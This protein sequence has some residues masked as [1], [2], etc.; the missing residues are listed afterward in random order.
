[1]INFGRDFLGPTQHIVPFQPGH[2]LNMDLREDELRYV[3][4]IPNWYQYLIESAEPELTWTALRDNEPY[5]CF[6][7]HPMWAGVSEVWMV[8]GRNISRNPIALV[9]GARHIFDTCQERLG[10]RRLQIAVR[11]HNETAYK[12]AKAVYFDVESVMTKYGPEGED[13][14]LMTRIR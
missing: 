4:L 1:M 11:K 8:T 14:F 6:G 9:K 2:L 13:Y 5:L 12:F 3:D 7:L 10:I